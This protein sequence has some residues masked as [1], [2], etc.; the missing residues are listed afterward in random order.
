MGLQ[1]DPDAN[2]RHDTWLSAQN[3]KP[4]LR[5]PADEERLIRDLVMERLNGAP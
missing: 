2:R 1:L 3:S 5:I 4:V